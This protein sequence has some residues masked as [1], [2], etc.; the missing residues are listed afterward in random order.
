MCVSKV[1]ILTVILSSVGNTFTENIKKLRFILNPGIGKIS[2][3]NN[4]V[5]NSILNWSS[6]V[7]LHI[8]NIIDK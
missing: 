7:K 2:N 4:V 3:L 1:T 8:I 6:V 5:I